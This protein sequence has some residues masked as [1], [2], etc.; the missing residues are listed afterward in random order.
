MRAVSD[1]DV[2]DP[3]LALPE[4]RQRAQ[5]HVVSLSTLQTTHRQEHHVVVRGHARPQR[6]PVDVWPESIGVDTGIDDVHARLGHTPLA[7][8]QLFRVLRVRN[9]GRRAAV[10]APGQ[11]CQLARSGRKA[12][13]FAVQPADVSVTVTSSGK[14]DGRA[15]PFRQRTRA[16]DHRRLMGE[17]PTDGASDSQMASQRRGPNDTPVRRAHR[18]ALN[19]QRPR[20]GRR[21]RW[22]LVR[23]HP[24][25]PARH[26]AV[27]VLEQ[28]AAAADRRREDL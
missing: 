17:S 9:H 1:D 4:P 19:L 14:R 8:Q 10:D 3:R 21:S 5:H 24:H 22:R 16:V 15:Q 20:V 2:P 18:D 12:Q 27:D 7:D 6:A 25:S 11:P 26:P 23:Q 13:L 28:R